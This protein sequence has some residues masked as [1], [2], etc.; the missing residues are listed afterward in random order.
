ML[1]HVS[2]WRVTQYDILARVRAGTRESVEMG[3]DRMEVLVGPELRVFPPGL[4]KA[5]QDL[6]TSD[7]KTDMK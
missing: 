2:V 6:I 4:P 5:T 1:N 7:H 3:L